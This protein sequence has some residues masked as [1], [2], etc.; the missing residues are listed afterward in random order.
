MLAKRGLVE[1]LVALTV[2]RNI[3]MFIIANLKK[4]KIKLRGKKF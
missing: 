4:L 1:N 3:T 2:T